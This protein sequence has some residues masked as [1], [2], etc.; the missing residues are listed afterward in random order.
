MMPMPS[1]QP[2][3]SRPSS[4]LTSRLLLP[5]RSPWSTF[6]A[7]VMVA[8]TTT[9]LPSRGADEADAGPIRESRSGFWIPARLGALERWEIETFEDPEDGASVRFIDDRFGTRADLY[10]YGRGIKPEEE[11]PGGEQAAEELARSLA[12]MRILENRHV[13][14]NVRFI[15]PHAAT[16]D[17]GHRVQMIHFAASTYDLPEPPGSPTEEHGDADTTT[18]T[19]LRSFRSLTAVTVYR[20]HFIRLRYT[21]PSGLRVPNGDTGAEQ[22]LGALFRMVAEHELRADVLDRLAAYRR[23]PL[24]SEGREAA[25]FLTTYAEHSDLVQIA[26]DDRVLAWTGGLDETREPTASG[27][28][29]GG[30]AATPTTRPSEASRELLT[31]FI[32]GNAG[33]QAEHEQFADAPVAGLR[34]VLATYRHLRERNP[35]L[36]IPELESLGRIE[37]DGALESHVEALQLAPDGSPAGHAEAGPTAAAAPAAGAGER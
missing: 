32:I 25:A 24:S 19:A 36:H 31:A 2:N 28:T 20:D 34:Q 15:D 26:L 17:L 35:E 8:A 11:S 4:P 9:P 12:A 37:A 27:E 23:D 13:Y 22:V 33:F 14:E 18:R 7:I 5:P 3:A 30:D 10:I 1:T 6:A 21:E 29:D 16:R